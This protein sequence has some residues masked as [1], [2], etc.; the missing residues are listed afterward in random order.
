[1]IS[2]EGRKLV[3]TLMNIFV[4]LI[5]APSTSTDVALINASHEL[6]NYIEKLEK[7]CKK[8]EKSVKN[9]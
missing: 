1:M 6:F 3:V 8:L 2:K 7:T 5:N 9:R 4:S